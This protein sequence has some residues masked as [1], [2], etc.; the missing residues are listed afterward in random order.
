MASVGRWRG[1]GWGRVGWGGQGGAGWSGAETFGGTFWQTLVCHRRAP[2]QQILTNAGT[3]LGP[4]GHWQRQATSDETRQASPTTIFHDCHSCNLFCI[5]LPCLFL[6]FP[7]LV[8]SC[9]VSY[10][11]VLYCMVSY[12]LVLF[13]LVLSCVVSSCLV[14]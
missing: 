5:I 10:R 7:C 9:N 13:R 2:R 12:G 3:K 4:V 6:S 14:M 1:V 8:L 11:I